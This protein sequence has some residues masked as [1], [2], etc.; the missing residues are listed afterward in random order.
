M[1][2]LASDDPP[3]IGRYRLRARLG[4]GG[5]GRVYLASTPAGPPVALK[6]VRPELS[7]DPTFRDRFRHEIQAAQR[8]RG[9]YT[10][11]LLDADPDGTPPWLV[12]AYVPGPSLTQ[13]VAEQGPMAEDQVLRLAAGV[14]EALQAIHAVNVVHRDLKPSN[15]VLGPDGPRVIDFGVARALE[16]TALTRSGAMVGTPQFMAPEQ[17]LGRPVTP[18][19]DVFALGGLAAYAAL[20]RGPFGEGHPAAVSHRVLYEHPDLAGCPPLVRALIEPC[21]AKQPDQRPSLTQILGF[22]LQHAPGRRLGPPPRHPSSPRHGS[23]HPGRAPAGVPV[24]GPHPPTEVAAGASGLPPTGPPPARPTPPSQVVNAVRLMYL[25]CVLTMAGFIVP[26]LAS[27]LL[28]TQAHTRGVAAQIATGGVILAALAGVAA[29]GLWLLMARRVKQGWRGARI[30]ATWF[31]VLN[32]IGVFTSNAEGLFTHLGFDFG[33]A[34]WGAGL[35][36][37]VFLW[38][39]RSGEFFTELRRARESA[40]PEWPKMIRVAATGH[41]HRRAS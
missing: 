35:I 15:V 19:I 16:A 26:A 36:A 17:I 5:M 13:A 6:V 40:T 31:F 29:G 10:A 34:E 33:L 28:G 4:A 25:G 1:Q 20:G 23:P 30:T 22:C 14:A 38:D 9:L 21:L 39:R 11:E 27:R 2:P 18:T 24:V 41:R 12:T 3:G 7:D 37:I 8:V 32:S